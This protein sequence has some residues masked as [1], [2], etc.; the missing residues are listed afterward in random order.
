[1]S[2][3]SLGTALE[4]VKATLDEAAR[5]LSAEEYADLL[6]ELSED[7]ELRHE[8]ARAKAEAD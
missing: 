2:K 3:Y 7:V 4:R 6:S 8:E 5:L 1:M